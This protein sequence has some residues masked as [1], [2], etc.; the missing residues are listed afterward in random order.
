MA[1]K[2]AINGFGRIGRCIVRALNERKES[3]LEVVSI[4][5][6][7]DA[8]TLAQV[9]APGTDAVFHLAAVVSGAAEA[10]FDLGLRVNLKGM[11]LLLE[12]MRRISAG[13]AKPPRLVY[14][15]SVAAFGGAL[16]PVLDDW[17]VD[18]THNLDGALDDADVVYLLRIQQE[19]MEQS[20]LPS[21]R[22]PSGRSCWTGR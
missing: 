21:L 14:T 13:G 17:P 19:R 4:N 11:E 20:L 1:R 5:D 8:K 16:P 12:Q 9:C 15:S 7:T 18:V 3:E 22:S 6:L 2:I 10:D